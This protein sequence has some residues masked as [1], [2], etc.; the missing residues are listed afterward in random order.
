LDQSI[1]RNLKR[2]REDMGISQEE[3]ARRMQLSRATISAVENGH[4]SIDSGKLLLAAS[5]LGQ[6]IEN[7]FQQEHDA[8]GFMY[9]A[10][11]DAIAPVDVQAKFERFCKSYCELEEI[12]GVMYAFLHPPDYSDSP[13]IHSDPL[14]F[15][16]LVARSERDRLGL[17]QIDPIENVFRVFDKAGLRLFRMRL[18]DDDVFGLSAFSVRLGACIFVN[19]ANTIERQIFSLSHEYGHTLMHRAFYRS[20]EPA[21]GLPKTHDLE[22]SANQFAACFLVPELVLRLIFNRDVPEKRVRIEDVV[23]LKHIFHVSAEM[24][25][26]RLTDLNLMSRPDSERLAAEFDARRKPKGEFAPLS[27]RII[28]DWETHRRFDDLLRR[29]YIGGRIDDNKLA[30]LL[31]VTRV[32]AQELS[33]SWR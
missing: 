1:G 22:L 3:F 20:P 18:E 6:A 15:A 28:Q 19:S 13:G 4:V 7:F 16:D 23:H 32:E 17:G 10:A 30:E 8:L 27:E 29:A 24:M 2:L 25:L 11:A 33:Q 12:L 5:V 21:A 31:G 26:R 14:L 9:R